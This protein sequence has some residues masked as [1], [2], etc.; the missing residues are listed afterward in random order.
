MSIYLC[1][2]CHGQGTVS[3]APH[4]D[5]D[6]YEWTDNVSGGYTCRICKGLGY[7]ME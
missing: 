4:I 5:G 1:P 3:K 6:V 7:V 2:L